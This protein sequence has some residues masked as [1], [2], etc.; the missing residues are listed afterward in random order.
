MNSKSLILLAGLGLLVACSDE[1]TAVGR[2]DVA[3]LLNGNSAAARVSTMTQNL[4]VG[5]DIDAVV[6]AL[7]LTPDDPTD[8]I[9]ALL[10]A[11][12]QLQATDFPTRAAAIADEIARRQPDVLALQEVSDIHLDLSI[13]GDPTVIDI[14]FLPI[15][16]A[17]LTARGLHYAVGAIVETINAEPVPGITLVDHDAV[18]VNDDRVT[19]EYSNAQT[20]VNNVGVIAPAW[21]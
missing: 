1:P 11:I 6:E 18:L 16:Q 17:Q 4:Y 5:A 21:T 13:F 15:L 20:Y 10:D 3:F 7:F 12:Q 8:D 2:S 19:V 14:A 9:R